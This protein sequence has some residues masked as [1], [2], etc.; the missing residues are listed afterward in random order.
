MYKDT[1]NRLFRDLVEQL[2][3]Y[4]HF[5]VN[6]YTSAP[7]SEDEMHE[8]HCQDLTKLQRIAFQHFKDKLTV[9]ALSNYASIDKREELIESLAGLMDEEIV[10]LCDLLH[11]RT[12][13]PEGT[14]VSV[15]RAFLT[16][17]LIQTFQKRESFL[18]EARKLTIYPNEVSPDNSHFSDHRNPS[19]TLEFSNTKH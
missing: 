17:V 1:K 3:H 16:E 5:A 8:M 7:M 13:Y 10:K 19:S 18:E 2:E 15:D 4:V 14:K 9:L 11:L 12:S 6:S